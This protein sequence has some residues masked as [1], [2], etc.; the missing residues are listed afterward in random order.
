MRLR[1]GH[2]D[3]PKFDERTHQARRAS[4]YASCTATTTTCGYLGNL[5]ESHPLYVTLVN[6]KLFKHKRYGDNN[7]AG[8]ARVHADFT[9]R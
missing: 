2:G 8:T 9:R 1:N 7:S 5:P 4:S 6:Q 3:I